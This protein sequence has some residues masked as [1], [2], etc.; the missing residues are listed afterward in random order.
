MRLVLIISLS[1]E[2]QFCNRSSVQFLRTW[3]NLLEDDVFYFLSALWQGDSVQPYDPLCS[4]DPL[5]E[6]TL[7]RWSYLRTGDRGQSQ[8][9]NW[10]NMSRNSLV[11]THVC[12]HNSLTSNFWHKAINVWR[13]ERGNLWLRSCLWSTRE[14]RSN[15]LD[16][17]WIKHIHSVYER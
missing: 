17:L 3:W 6:I 5:I 11:D 9:T 16:N 7:S 8:E 2:H 15:S 10:E 14:Q 12:I 1:F 13:E 4:L